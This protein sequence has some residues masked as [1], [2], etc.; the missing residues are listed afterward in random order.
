MRKFI[1]YLLIG[2]TP[3]FSQAELNYLDLKGIDA[4]VNHPGASP[5]YGCIALKSHI[6]NRRFLGTTDRKMA[7]WLPRARGSN[8]CLADRESRLSA[9]F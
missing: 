9:G 6:E 3:T 2:L 7:A 5:V 8:S 1:P 4:L